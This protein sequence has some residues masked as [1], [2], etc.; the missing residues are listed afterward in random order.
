MATFHGTCLCRGIRFEVDAEPETLRFCHCTSC[1]HLSG[2]AGTVNF[3]VAPSAIRIVAGEDLIQTFAP[4]GGSAK[5][6]CRNCG[7]NLFGGGWPDSEHCS[8]RV[9]TIEEPLDA[10]I[11]V[12]LYVRS[13]APWESLPDDG[14]DRFETTSS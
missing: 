8:V 10:K 13:L 9:T 5:T 6:F 7:A 12:H 1:K 3:G 2:G 14:A 11:G 4:E